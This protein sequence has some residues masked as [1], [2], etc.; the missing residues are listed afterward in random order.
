MGAC[1]AKG[2]TVGEPGESNSKQ[3][4]GRSV[5]YVCPAP[6]EDVCKHLQFDSMP[7][8]AVGQLVT[9]YKATGN[10]SGCKRDVGFI[11]GTPMEKEFGAE[12][13]E[14]C[15]FAQENGHSYAITKSKTSAYMPVYRGSL[16]ASKIPDCTDKC[17]VTFSCSY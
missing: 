14:T 16:L 15:I 1:Q 5:E 11:D 3:W 7:Q 17:L 8:L 9:E 6:Y 12:I 2:D 4:G 13:E 10:A